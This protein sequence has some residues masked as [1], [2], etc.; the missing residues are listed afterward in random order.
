MINQGE[1]QAIQ[2]IF[3]KFV[4]QKSV[5]GILTLLN[6]GSRASKERL[7]YHG[8]YR[9]LIDSMF[10]NT[11]DTRLPQVFV[12]FQHAPEVGWDSFKRQ[13]PNHNVYRDIL[14]IYGYAYQK[15]LT[16]LLQNPTAQNGVMPVALK[17]AIVRRFNL[18]THKLVLIPWFAE[19]LFSIT[20]SHNEREGNVTATAIFKDPSMGTVS[21]TVDLFDT[22]STANVP[23]GYISFQ[24]WLK[25]GNIVPS[26]FRGFRQGWFGIA[27][28]QHDSS[29][30]SY[31]VY[32]RELAEDIE[33]SGGVD[34]IYSECI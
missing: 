8:G 14:I 10:P 7:S 26:H 16:R 11:L 25:F 15:L 30:L 2:S 5:G 29:V 34:N 33:N 3:D 22:N 6:A 13:N 17:D 31:I 9:G 21:A 20:Y 12:D 27:P 28:F 4:I 32:L 23:R 18:S 19:H 1:R 24:T